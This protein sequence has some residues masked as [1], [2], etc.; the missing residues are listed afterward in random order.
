MFKPVQGEALQNFDPE[1]IELFRRRE[2]NPAET[3]ELL[4]LPRRARHHLPIFVDKEKNKEVEQ[5]EK[6][7][8]QFF[9]KVMF[10][11]GFFCNQPINPVLFEP[12]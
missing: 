3:L 12:L 9:W 8:G 10:G 11:A 7:H 5:W 4:Q 2:A 1:T 6:E